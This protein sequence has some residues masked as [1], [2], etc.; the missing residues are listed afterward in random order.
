MF[1]LIFTS[2]CGMKEENKVSTKSQPT[3]K[4]NKGLR[5][6]Q[7]T[8]STINSFITFKGE[9][10]ILV[11]EYS[12]TLVEDSNLQDD[13]G[14]KIQFSNLVVGQKVRANISGPIRESYPAQAD[15]KSL[16]LLTDNESINES[17][18]MA[19]ALEIEVT[20]GS[21]AIA[22]GVIFD[23]NQ[24]SYTVKLRFINIDNNGDKDILIPLTM[25]K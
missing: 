21:T 7:N 15:L 20:E 8:L 22:L 1:G 13:Q 10:S 24:K 23:P 25:I 11:G 3:N 9:K 2:G 14:K 18:A 4:E 17:K 5:N 6:S 19:K 12:F 16:V